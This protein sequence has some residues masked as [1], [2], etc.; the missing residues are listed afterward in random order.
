MV[1]DRKMRYNAAVIRLQNKKEKEIRMSGSG[2]LERY[3]VIL[4]LVEECKFGKMSE[5]LGKMLEKELGYTQRYIDNAFSFVTGLSLTKYLQLR[6]LSAIFEY[7]EENG[8]SWDE[9]GAAF[10][11]A[12]NSFRRTFKNMY[13]CTPKDVL[14]GKK[15]VS[16]MPI[17]SLETVLKCEYEKE[18]LQ[19][20]ISQSDWSSL[21]RIQMNIRCMISVLNRL[22]SQRKLQKN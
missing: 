9:A 18:E 8:C 19:M 11:Y 22:N 14:M 10:G 16:L 7:K 20:N 2:F 5:D 21:G 13:G 12:D 15:S 17:L 6:K 3:E 4:Q 1:S